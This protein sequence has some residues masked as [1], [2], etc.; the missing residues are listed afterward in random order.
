MV[1]NETRPTV[2]ATLIMES[3]ITLVGDLENTYRI[4]IKT[5]T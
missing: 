3:H 4:D 2:H 5:I 1:V